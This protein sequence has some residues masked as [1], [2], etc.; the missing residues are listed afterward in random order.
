MELHK[1]EYCEARKSL[2]H[3]LP[4]LQQPNFANLRDPAAAAVMNVAKPNIRKADDTII[5]DEGVSPNKKP[6]LMFLPQ[7]VTSAQLKN[8]HNST[9]GGAGPAGIM[10]FSKTTIHPVPAQQVQQVAGVGGG[11]AS[12]SGLQTSGGLLQIASRGLPPSSMMTSQPLTTSE[13]FARPELKGIIPSTSSTSG[14]PGIPVPSMTGVLTGI[15]STPSQV[16]FSLPG[17][18][19]D[20]VP[21]NDPLHAAAKQVKIPSS[22]TTAP[23]MPSIPG[24]PGPS[25]DQQST[26]SKPVVIPTVTA[27]S[28]MK[29]EIKVEIGDGKGCEDAKFRRPDSLPLTPG[30]FKTKKHV[31]LVSGTNTLVSPDTPRPRKSYMLQYQ[32][33]T[34]YTTLGLKCSTKE[35]FTT[36]FKQQPMYV[37]HKQGISMYSN[38]KMVTKDSHPSGL[39]PSQSLNAYC[40]TSHSASHG[41]FTTAGTNPKLSKSDSMVVSHSSKWKALKESAKKGLKAG[42]GADEGSKEASENA[43]PSNLA[44]GANPNSSTSAS[45]VARTVEGGYKSLDDDYTYVR[46]RG[47][48]RYVCDSCGIRCK[49]PSM[50]KKHIR[51]HSNFR[52]YT[53]KYC[54]FAFK[55]KGNL[56]KHMKSK[57]H[58]KK[59]IELGITPVPTTIPD[60]FNINMP[61]IGEP[62]PSGLN[63]QDQAK[64]V[65][66]DSD[67]DD[68]DMEDD[69]DEDD[70]QFEDADDE[71]EIIGEDNSGM[72]AQGLLPFKPKLST[73]PY[74]SDIVKKETSSSVVSPSASSSSSSLSPPIAN[75]ANANP[76]AANTANVVTM[77]ESLQPLSSQAPVIGEKYYFSKTPISNDVAKAAAAT[78]MAI[79]S[80]AINAATTTSV[81]TKVV[82]TAIKETK[83]IV[84]PMVDPPISTSTFNPDSVPMTAYIQ[85]KA[86]VKAAS[87]PG[88]ELISS[89]K[90]STSSADE[91]SKTTPE[92]PAV[93]QPKIEPNENLAAFRNV[94]LASQNV[95]KENLVLAPGS[96]QQPVNLDLRPMTPV[97]INI[98]RPKPES[99]TPMD[100]HTITSPPNK[101]MEEVNKAEKIM[102][103]SN[104]NKSSI[105]SSPTL[106]SNDQAGTSTNHT[107]S[108]GKYVCNTC[109]RGFPTP[110]VL[111]CH[112]KIHLFERNFRCD[113]CSVSFRTSG[114]LQKHKR[115]SGHFN[116][117]NINATFGEP[118]A[119]NPRPFYCADCKIGFRIHGHLAKHLRSK[120]HIMK[121][122]NCGKLPIGMYAE[123]ERLG[124]NFN[125]IDT[126]SCE[127]SLDSLK[128]L[129][130]KLSKTDN[131]SVDTK[132][133][134]GLLGSP[135]HNDIKEEPLEP[136]VKIVDPEMLY[137]KSPERQ[138][139]PPQRPPHIP[140]PNGIPNHVAALNLTKPQLKNVPPPPLDRRASFSSSGQDDPSTD[141][142]AVSFLLKKTQCCQLTM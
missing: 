138:Q 50:L 139:L 69:D 53:C 9:G 88:F 27:D 62:G 32:N 54:N 55:T 83:P 113:A 31:M 47:R 35:Y 28:P 108:N 92:L 115:S 22:V 46:G 42:G 97:D 126:S 105:P 136:P 76:N 6:K 56:T 10:T 66:G 121:L 95:A 128:S 18:R 91:P 24:I 86:A 70:E 109:K 3:P 124:T 29:N 75:A 127:S 117:V 51:T 99:P 110:T 80:S 58:H 81:N 19:E 78:V 8:L 71:V 20:F 112:Q 114:H 103:Q 23:T 26:I 133:T 104:A 61:Q 36:I 131:F 52:P 107:P 33:G 7:Q 43:N 34:A 16:L 59:C 67:S 40:S 11:A 111:N 73:Y 72:A 137:R 14:I 90:T 98:K 119:T 65:A 60:D 2:V 74:N 77:K 37:A 12:T 63:G 87:S 129:A 68:E 94:S 135:T 84:L 125:E 5:L 89:T 93:Q 122:E 17:K 85:A 39:S 79:A 64:P 140:I 118:S 123:M 141:S 38:W 49:K 142:E 102:D 13:T 116:K 100:I 101:T 45:G 21:P 57:T 1:R 120:S 96:N 132:H 4:T 44:T 134:N 82:S 30:S 41:L 106:K 25:Q 15:K 130:A 48:G